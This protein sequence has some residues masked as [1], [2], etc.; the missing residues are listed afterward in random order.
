MTDVQDLCL[1]GLENRI[2]LTKLRPLGEGFT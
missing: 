2:S 1:S